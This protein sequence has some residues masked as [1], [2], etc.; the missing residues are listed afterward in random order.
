MV[1]QK[2]VGG[3][4]EGGTNVP[5]LKSVQTSSRSNYRGISR[6]VCSIP[7]IK[8]MKNYSPKTILNS[9]KNFPEFVLH[10]FYQ[11][12]DRST[13]IYPKLL[14]NI[15]LII[16]LSGQIIGKIDPIC[17]EIQYNFQ[18]VRRRHST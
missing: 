3:W 17:P 10:K 18:Y 12:N 13:K 16:N 8:S 14:I 1:N 7:S 15:T 5:I 4:G 6:S 2:G 11:Q 9:P